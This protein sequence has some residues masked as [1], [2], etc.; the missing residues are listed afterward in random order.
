MSGTFV[1]SA[2]ES[3]VTFARTLDPWECHRKCFPSVR[4]CFTV[5]KHLSQSCFADLHQY[6]RR[7][8]NPPS[9]GRLFFFFPKRLPYL[10]N[11]KLKQESLVAHRLMIWCGH[12]RWLWSLLW[13]SFKP[14]SRNFGVLLVWPRKEKLNLSC[15]VDLLSP[16]VFFLQF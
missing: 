13:C 14:W 7:G 15:R 9:V 1:F 10:S 5:I 3:L 11:E 8:K 4:P 6:E 2:V 16:L 12:C